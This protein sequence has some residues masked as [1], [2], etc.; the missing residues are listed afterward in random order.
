MFYVLLINVQVD[1][2]NVFVQR[3]HHCS[4]AFRSSETVTKVITFGGCLVNPHSLIQHD[5]DLLPVAVANL[6][7]LGE[8][9]WCM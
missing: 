4:A 3:W 8:S 6:V 5:D 2:P 9:Y 1:I 7:V